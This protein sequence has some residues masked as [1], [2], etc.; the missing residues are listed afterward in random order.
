MELA[1]ELKLSLNEDILDLKVLKDGRVIFKTQN[2]FKLW[3]K[4]QKGS[5][6]E[7]TENYY[8]SVKRLEIKS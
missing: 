2:G 4:D 6:T 5:I 8:Q 1:E 7:I 3:L